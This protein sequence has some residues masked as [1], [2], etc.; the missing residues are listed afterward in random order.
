MVRCFFTVI[1]VF[2]IFLLMAGSGEAAKTVVMDDLRY[3]GFRQYCVP[4]DDFSL[5]AKH[6]INLYAEPKAGSRIIGEVPPDEEL[7]IKEAKV[8]IYPN[9]GRA[10]VT[11]LPTM[12][13]GI[14]GQT[15]NVGDEIC[16]VYMITGNYYQGCL[17]LADGNFVYLNWREVFIPETDRAGQSGGEKEVGLQAIKYLGRVYDKKIFF[18]LVSGKYSENVLVCRNA[19]VW[20]KLELPDK[21]AGWVEIWQANA[22]LEQKEKLFDDWYCD[23]KDNM[24]HVNLMQYFY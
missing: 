21:D 18:D 8:I 7:L 6:S 12:R 16:L 1:Q 17:A 15:P 5:M 10:K 14:P 3:A 4:G 11:A 20:V 9:M 13:Y 24:R 23:T 22:G 19:D 2:M